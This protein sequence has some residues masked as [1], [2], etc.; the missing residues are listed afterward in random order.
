[1]PISIMILEDHQSTLDGLVHGLS[2]EPDFTIV[3]TATNSD[4]GCELAERLRPEIVLLDL[5]VP[6]RTGP[7]SM[8][9][10]FSRI[11]GCRLIVFSAENR[12]AYIQSVLSMGV[13]AYLLKSERLSTVAETIRQVVAGKKAILS[14]ELTAAAKKFTISEQEVLDMLGRGMKYQDIADERGTS[15][16]TVRKQCETLL[17]KLGL[18]TREQLIAWAVKNGYGTLEP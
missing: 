6:G 3:G 12:M 10:A 5:H 2:K 9:E 13:A 15:V 1:M 7:R 16:A 18:E 4:E 11:P 8:V 17:L 14:A